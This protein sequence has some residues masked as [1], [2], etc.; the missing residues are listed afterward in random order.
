MKQIVVSVTNDLVTDQRVHRVCSTLIKENY[1]VLLIGRRYADTQAIDRNYS[2]HRMKLFFNEGFLFYAEFNFRLFIK[3]L[4][5]KKDFLISN[6]LDTLLPNYLI[7]KMFRKKLL[8]DS[9][10]L[11]T[12]VP[13]LI[14][15]PFIKKVWLFI[16]RSLV[17]NLS[18]CFTVSQSIAN[19][20]NKRYDSKFKVLRNLPYKREVDKSSF[21]FN[22][23]N[24][25]IILYQGAI[26]MGRGLELMIDTM[27]YLENTLFIVIG[28]GDLFDK[29]KNNVV[30]RGLDQKVKFLGRITPDI[31]SKLTPLAHIGISLEEDLGLNYRYALPNKLF[32]YIQ[33]RIPVIVSDL[34]EMRKVVEEFAVGEVLRVRSPEVLSKLIIDMLG[35]RK[36]HWKPQ[37]QTA[38]QTLIWEKEEIL[39][40]KMFNNL[41]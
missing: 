41:T 14:N 11:F 18:N 5:I 32:D 30:V 8:Y 1:K 40:K 10:E 2:I 9:H 34:P 39:I 6:D 38:S 4:F 22:T 12:E 29:L 31:L 24:K 37:L 13:E 26:N 19:H 33:A 16:E 35:K 21:P 7:S 3:L 36:G 25:N 27:D 17:R 20:Y 23:N 28:D 15:R